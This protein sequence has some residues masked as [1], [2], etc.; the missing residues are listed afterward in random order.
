MPTHSFD[1]PRLIDHALLARL[2]DVDAPRAVLG[3]SEQPFLHFSVSGVGL[4]VP[5][6]HVASVSSVDEPTPVPGAPK[7]ILGLVAVGEHVLPLL[8]LAAFLEL[9]SPPAKLD[10]AFRRTLFVAADGYEAGLVCSRAH[11]IVSV[12]T[13]GLLA[14]SVLQGTGLRR[15]LS[16]EL[17]LGTGIVG[18][19]D[20]P[21]LLHSAS[22]A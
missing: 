1:R 18:V 12:P 22:V 7:H 5:A 6:L 17:D 3:Q 10:P 21:S 20:L 2:I 19:L 14:P 16:A 4:A 9:T 11:G 13:S 15:F 8:D